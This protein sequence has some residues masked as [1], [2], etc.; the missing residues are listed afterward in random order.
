MKCFVWYS[1]FVLI[2]RIVLALGM[3]IAKGICIGHE[4]VSVVARAVW[5]VENNGTPVISASSVLLVKISSP[6]SGTGTLIVVLDD[7]SHAYTD[8]LPFPADRALIRS[9]ATARYGSSVVAASHQHI[10]EVSDNL[11][12][13]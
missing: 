5:S 10:Y 12:D 8:A 3:V 6:R 2:S 1:S 11:S 9:F 7:Q 4:L 13:P